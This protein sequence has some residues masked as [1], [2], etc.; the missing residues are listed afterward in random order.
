MVFVSAVLIALAVT[1][2][3]TARDDPAPVRLNGGWSWEGGLP[4]AAL[5]ASALSQR[6]QDAIAAALAV[7]NGVQHESVRRV[8]TVKGAGDGL[9]L[10]SGAGAN[11]EPCFTMLTE[12]GG[13]REFSCLGS[14]AAEDAIVRF[15]GSAGPTIDVINRVTL[16]GIVRSDVVR[17]MLVTAT[18]AE[19]ELP[20][21]EW[22]AFRFT[23]TSPDS[24]PAALRAYDDDGSLIEELS[25][26]P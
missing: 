7:S 23:T 26:Y 9:T 20:L 21:N 25:T 22:R 10:L 16:V 3:A 5:E 15:V 13:T 17:V 6:S 1:L 19:R 14:F 12:L 18:G 4:G 24:F 11:G 2:G 8:V